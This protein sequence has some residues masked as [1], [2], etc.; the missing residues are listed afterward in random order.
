MTTLLTSTVQYTENELF[1]I[2]NDIK[3]GQKTWDG[4]NKKA[5]LDAMITHIGSPTSDLREL[6][7][8]SFCELI[9][10]NQLEHKVLIELMDYSLDHLLH[11]GIG[12]NKTDLV[13]T[14]AF[15][16]LLID[17]II[18]KDNE[19]DFLP[20][21]TVMKVKDAVIQ[22]IHLE[23]DL[24][25]YVPVKGWAHSVAHV[26]DTCG[27][28]LKSEKIDQK[29]YF[30]ILAPLLKNYCNAQTVFV[31]GEDDRVV[32]PVLTMLNKG[33]GGEALAAFVTEIPVN[34]IAQKEEL[35]P[36]VYWYVMANCRSLLKSLYLGV[37]GDE[38]YVSLA[39]TV[40]KSLSAI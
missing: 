16:T 2:L 29:D 11:K 19:A 15:T 39:E 27:E 31:H 36:E 26:A 33:V 40:K 38:N 18:Y 17:V 21:E 8:R 24:R 34:L 3:N 9:V 7:Y 14:R 32:K 20:K 4:E 13:F 23:Q 10:D 28:L 12:E 5:I 37:S 6:V 35:E 22:Y 25:G 30:Q 1:M